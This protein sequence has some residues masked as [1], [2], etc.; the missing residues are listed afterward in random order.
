ML[1]HEA[2]TILVKMAGWDKGR[3]DSDT[4][5]SKLEIKIRLFSHY[6]PIT[7]FSLKSPGFET[8]TSSFMEPMD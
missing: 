7:R 8:S 2:I 5:F 4:D 6:W 1:L 3:S